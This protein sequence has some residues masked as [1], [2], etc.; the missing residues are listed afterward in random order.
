MKHKVAANMD[1]LRNEPVRACAPSRAQGP[2][3]ALIGGGRDTVQLAKQFANLGILAVICADDLQEFRD[4]EVTP[5]HAAENVVDRPDVTAVAITHENP[6]NLIRRALSHG[7]DMYVHNGL[8]LSADEAEEA[9]ASASRQRRVLMLANPTSQHPAVQKLRQL[10]SVGALGK[11]VFVQV[12]RISTVELSASHLED[13]LTAVAL[14]NDK[15]LDVACSTGISGEQLHVN[16]SVSSVRFADGRAAFVFASSVATLND[17]RIIAHA[18]NNRTAIIREVEGKIR[19]HLFDGRVQAEVPHVVLEENVGSVIGL[20]AA[21]VHLQRLCREFFEH[22]KLRSI[23][24]SASETLQLLRVTEACQRSR[25]LNGGHVTIES[26]RG[27]F[28][29]NAPAV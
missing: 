17:C 29:E 24:G 6:A 23:P 3:L 26:F 25:H 11:I 22:L 14:I 4:I 21:E 7:K 18:N 13:I 19:L 27:S 5:L 20:D 15:P 10:G 8:G 1:A 12:E 9:Y 28:E 16:N 2:Q